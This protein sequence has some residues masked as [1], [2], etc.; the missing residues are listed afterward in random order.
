M[1]SYDKIRDDE[2]E[3]AVRI[4]NIVSALASWRIS[5][6]V[7]RF[8]M[9]LEL[10]L[11]QQAG[12]DQIPVEILKSLPYP[13][14]IWNLR[15]CRKT[16]HVVFVYYDMD[17]YGNDV[18]KFLVLC[19]N[20]QEVAVRGFELTEGKTLRECIAEVLKKRYQRECVD[21]KVREHMELAE[22]M[23][24]L[25]LYI[26]SVNADIQ[27]ADPKPSGTLRRIEDIKD[28]YREIRKW[29]VGMRM[30]SQNRRRTEKHIKKTKQQSGRSNYEPV[31][32]YRLAPHVR[33]GHW[34]TY[35]T[36]KKDGSAKRKLILKWIPFTYVNVGK[37]EEL[38]TVVNVMKINREIK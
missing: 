34:H 36:G 3:N 15:I 17:Q 23:L 16:S 14:F 31:V 29:D 28:C 33:R 20:G 38:P 35:W 19:R 21:D 5:K 11:Y 30:V 4:A 27:S 2:Y 32:H 6:Q 12:D 26:C 8:N 10:A 37:L 1:N 13:A 24:Q 9:E 18:L 22:K 7:Y 25:V